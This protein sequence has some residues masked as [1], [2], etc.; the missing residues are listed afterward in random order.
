LLGGILNERAVHVCF[1]NYGGQPM[2]RGFWRDLVPFLN[3]LH[4]DHL[5]LE[6]ARRGY[7][8]LE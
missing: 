7:G 3:S 6:F 2:L 5:V 1:G 4:A 8:E